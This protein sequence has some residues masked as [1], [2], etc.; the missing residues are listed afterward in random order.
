MDDT[1]TTTIQFQRQQ[2]YDM[3]KVLSVVHNTTIGRLLE[4][5]EDKELAAIV[6]DPTKL[7]RLEAVAAKDQRLRVI[8]DRLKAKHGVR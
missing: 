1:Y 3:L 4:L 7:H 2:D 8:V 6:Q 5:L